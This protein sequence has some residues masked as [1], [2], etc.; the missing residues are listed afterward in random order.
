MACLA[1]LVENSW[2]AIGNCGAGLQ[3]SVLESCSE[4]GLKV[5]TGVPGILVYP[6][7]WGQ[8]C[9]VLPDSGHSSLPRLRSI[10]PHIF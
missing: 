8:L 5:D 3:S 4:F 7:F 10:N 6:A 9:L 1:L 2:L